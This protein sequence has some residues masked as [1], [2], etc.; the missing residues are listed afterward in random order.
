MQ[1]LKV[2][3]AGDGTAGK[4]SLLHTFTTNTFPDAYMP[5]VYENSMKVVNLE[6]DGE[7]KEIGLNLWDTA[8]ME[9]YEKLRV[10][11]YTKTDVF[12]LCFS[13]I[14]EDSFH[15]VKDIWITELRKYEPKTPVILVGTKNDLREENRKGYY[16]SKLT[17]FRQG[18]NLA[19]QIGAVKYLECSALTEEGVEAVFDEAI[20][21]FLHPNKQTSL[22]QSVCCRCF[23]SVGTLIQHSDDTDI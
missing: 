3:L 8:G 12:L 14:N 4:T 9:D 21:T 1:R 10:L 13:I 15:N 23:P 22:I 16:Y 19:A 5:T 2:V 20:R 17:T 6:D 7:L 18:A 11:A